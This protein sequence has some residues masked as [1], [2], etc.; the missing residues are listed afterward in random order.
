MAEGRDSGRSI[1]GVRNGA[2]GLCVPTTHCGTNGRGDGLRSRRGRILPLSRPY[3]A[4]YKVI[5]NM[6]AELDITMALTGCRTLADI[7]GAEMTG[8]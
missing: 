6:E 8:R 7:A 5:R 1:S 2:G 3:K 4:I